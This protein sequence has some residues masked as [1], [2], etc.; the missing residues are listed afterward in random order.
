MIFEGRF[1]YCYILLSDEISLS[2][3]PYLQKIE[4]LWEEKEVLRWN[5]KH[6]S[7][8]SKGFHWSKQNNHFLEGES[9]TLI[10]W[11]P[12]TKNLRH[13]LIPCK[14]ILFRPFCHFRAVDNSSEKSTWVTLMV[15]IVQNFRKNNCTYYENN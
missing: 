14:D 13:R 2:G 12:P 3:C 8:F 11:P 5:K 6:F 10:W 15:F 7:S 1:F 9:P 4:M